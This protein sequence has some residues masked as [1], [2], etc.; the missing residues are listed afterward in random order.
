LEPEAGFYR[1]SFNSEKV[2]LTSLIIRLSTA[3]YAD[4]GADFSS[5]NIL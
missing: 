5:K 2:L 1:K 4:L 3:P